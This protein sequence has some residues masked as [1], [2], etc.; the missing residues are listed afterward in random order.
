MFLMQAHDMPTRRVVV[1][2]DDDGYE[3]PVSA[4]TY[5]DEAARD[6]AMGWAEKFIEEGG[7]RPNGPLKLDR[8]EVG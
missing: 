6:L 5:T 1:F 4:Q 8:I 7:W 3:F 2:V